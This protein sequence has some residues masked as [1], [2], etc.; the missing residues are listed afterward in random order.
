[1]HVSITVP[2][3]SPVHCLTLTNGMNKLNGNIRMYGDIK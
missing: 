3:F 2:D 1:M